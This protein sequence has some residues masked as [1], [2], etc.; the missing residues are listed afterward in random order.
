MQKNAEM[1]SK[2]R[3][4]SW[5]FGYSVVI[6]IIRFANLIP[7]RTVHMR[8]LRA[9]ERK[10]FCIKNCLKINIPTLKSSGLGHACLTIVFG[11]WFV[12]GIMSPQKTA[13]KGFFNSSQQKLR[14]KHSRILNSFRHPDMVSNLGHF[15]ESGWTNYSVLL[16]RI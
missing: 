10:W 2:I 5:F 16:Q 6:H 11:S 3:E 14:I 1:F 7:W 4:Y 8:S 9:I 15:W 12:R 13:T